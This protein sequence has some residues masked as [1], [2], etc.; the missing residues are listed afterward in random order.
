MKLYM[1]KIIDSDL[2]G[3]NTLTLLSAAWAAKTTI[4]NGRTIPRYFDFCD[5]H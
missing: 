3:A 5:E 4:T 1:T 2:L